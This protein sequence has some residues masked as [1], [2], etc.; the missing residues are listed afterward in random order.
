MFRW[1]TRFVYVI[2]ALYKLCYVLCTWLY[3]DVWYRRP[4]ERH[5][6]HRTL[7]RCHGQFPTIYNLND[8]S[9]GTTRTHVHMYNG[10]L[11]LYIVCCICVRIL[12][13]K[14][15]RFFYFRTQ[16]FLY[17]FQVFFLLWISVI[18]MN[19]RCVAWKVPVYSVI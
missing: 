3:N 8:I 18:S 12:V 16:W 13:Y 9:K 4:S 15:L 7:A 2:A 6:S 1:F 10:R 19:V 11:V 14:I 17:N 5:V